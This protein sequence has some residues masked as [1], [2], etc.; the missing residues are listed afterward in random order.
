MGM[1]LAVDSNRGQLKLLVGKAIEGAAS[2]ELKAALAKAM[3]LWGK[4][5][6]S[7]YAAQK[8]VQALLPAAISAA[9]VELKA[10]LAMLQ[11]LSDYF[12]D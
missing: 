11:S 7:A 9:P 10:D 6:D 4:T 5:D 3:E 8:A 1:R 2:P 12:V